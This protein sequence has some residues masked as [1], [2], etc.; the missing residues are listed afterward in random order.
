[1]SRPPLRIAGLFLL[2]GSIGVIGVGVRA[3]LAEVRADFRP[4]GGRVVRPPALADFEDVQF[5]AAGALIR[6]W[7]A[8]S[9][10]GALVILLHGTQAAR[11]QLATEAAALSRA[12]YGVLMFDFPGHGASTGRVTWGAGERQALVAALDLA[13][14]QRPLPRRIGVLAFSMGSMIA[15]QVAANDE[16][17]SALVLTGPIDDPDTV[18]ADDFDSLGPLTAM[19]AVWAAHA[20]GMNPDG[21]RPVDLISRIAPRPIMLITGAKDTDV[22]PGH[23]RALFAA[24]LQPKTFWTIDGAHHG[25]YYRVAGPVYTAGLIEFFD[26]TLGVQ[27]PQR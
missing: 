17:I 16:R 27:R 11:V 10:N 14:R 22:K 19:P 5:P 12:G 15:V 24:A 23:A 8:P 2:L 1:V 25:D 4:H 6:G 26:R 3:G 13:G 21:Q 20:E 9:Q 18:I 7:Y